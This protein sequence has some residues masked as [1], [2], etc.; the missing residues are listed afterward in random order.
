MELKVFSAKLV[1]DPIRVEETQ[2][3]VSG[4]S[5]AARDG[6][7]SEH[8]RTHARTAAPP[9]QGEEEEQA[10][11]CIAHIM[12]HAT[13]QLLANWFWEKCFLGRS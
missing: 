1:L 13:S 12:I 9:H 4:G 2:T 10:V 11:L 3:G 7:E 6:R 5:T 8:A